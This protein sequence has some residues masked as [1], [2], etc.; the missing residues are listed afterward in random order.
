V[1]L[2]DIEQLGDAL[3]F[4]DLALRARRSDGAAKRIAIE[5]VIINDKNFVFDNGRFLRLWSKV[6]ARAESLLSMP[7][8][9]LRDSTRTR[10]IAQELGRTK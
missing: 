1:A 8:G 4:E 10:T 7:P 5:R 2:Q 3:R 9:L 6:A